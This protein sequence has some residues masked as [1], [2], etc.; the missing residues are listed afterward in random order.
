MGTSFLTLFPSSMQTTHVHVIIT[1]HGGV[2]GVFPRISC[3][4]G[5]FPQACLIIFHYDALHSPN[6]EMNLISQKTRMV[7]LSPG[8]DQMSLA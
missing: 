4:S 5:L 6:F 2:Y 1:T 3:T 8:E 7:W